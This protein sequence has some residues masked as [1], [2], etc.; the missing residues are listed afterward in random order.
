MD[1]KAAIHEHIRNCCDVLLAYVKEVEPLHAERWVPAAEIKKALDI[2][3]V[4]APKANTPRGEKGWF[5]AT[6]ARML[7]DQGRLQ[8]ERRGSRSYC[9]SVIS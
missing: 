8:Y 2:N 4:A 1:H 3:F 5:F 9:R 6:L 7:E